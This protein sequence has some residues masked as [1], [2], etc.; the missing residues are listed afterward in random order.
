M[1]KSHSKLERIRKQTLQKNSLSVIIYDS[2]CAL[3]VD[4]A[5]FAQSFLMKYNIFTSLS[6]FKSVMERPVTKSDNFIFIHR[7]SIYYGHEAWCQILIHGY[8][9]LNWLQ[10]IPGT[11]T[12]IKAIYFIVSKL[13]KTVYKKKKG[14]NC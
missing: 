10:K 3:C 12:I 4:A 5:N 11:M 2:D 7:G 9:C 13:R 6:M 14:C 1:E 8:K